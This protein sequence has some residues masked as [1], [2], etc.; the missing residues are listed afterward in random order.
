MQNSVIEMIF[1][2]GDEVQSAIKDNEEYKKICR[3]GLE[4]YNKLKEKLNKKQIKLLEK[5]AD[6]NLDIEGTACE[7]YFKEGFKTGL[8]LAVECL[9]DR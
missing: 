7:I 4:L 8:R 2:F 6:A 5:S 3:N 9:T 1:N